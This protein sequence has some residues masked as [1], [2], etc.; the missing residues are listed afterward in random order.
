MDSSS[1]R[2]AKPIHLS[3][4]GNTGFEF[5]PKA[6]EVV[7]LDRSGRTIWQKRKGEAP[8]PIRWT[9][10]DTAGTTVET[11]DYICKIVYPND[12]IAYLP[13]VFVKKA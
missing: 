7:I 6:T 1:M 13:F 11:G 12:K 8:A 3:R 4:H 5:D 2:M 10:I 9:G